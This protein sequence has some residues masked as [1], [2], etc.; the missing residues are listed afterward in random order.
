FGATPARMSGYDSENELFPASN[1]NAPS[2]TYVSESPCRNITCV[3]KMA[4]TCQTPR[5]FET[6]D[7]EKITRD[8]LKYL[9]DLKAPSAAWTGKAF[10]KYSGDGVV[11]AMILLT[12]KK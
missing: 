9:K 11:P 4:K 5:C 1:Q 10:Q 2:K 6:L 8:I 12:P 7:V 3:N